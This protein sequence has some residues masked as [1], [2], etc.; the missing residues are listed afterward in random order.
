M[1]A[2]ERDTY[3]EEMVHTHERIV[4]EAYAYATCLS[5]T[6]GDGGMWHALTCML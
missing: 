4:H 1:R 6:D 3:K 2:R 5:L